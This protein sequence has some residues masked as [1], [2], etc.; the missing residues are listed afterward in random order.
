MKKQAETTNRLFQKATLGLLF[1]VTPKCGP[2][3]RLGG[4]REKYPKTWC[5]QSC[6]SRVR[7]WFA[8]L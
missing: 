6:Q 4:S 8:L 3:V 1:S 5:L 2:R 7:S